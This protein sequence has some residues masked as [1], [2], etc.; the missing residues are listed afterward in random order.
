MKVLISENVELLDEFIF[1]ETSTL[2]FAILSLDLETECA[3][4][5]TKLLK[6]VL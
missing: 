1:F 3:R 2:Y 5:N 6:I 4:Y